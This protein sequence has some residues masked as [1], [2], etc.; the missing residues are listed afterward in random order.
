MGWNILLTKR[1]TH[2]LSFI[3]YTADT[4]EET[5]MIGERECNCEISDS[6]SYKDDHRSSEWP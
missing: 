2:V 5:T 1:L 4:R 6:D 3:I